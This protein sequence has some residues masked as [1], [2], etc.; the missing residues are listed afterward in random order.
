MD[1]MFDMHHPCLMPDAHSERL[2]EV[3]VPLYMQDEFYPNAQIYPIDDV[4][5]TV[6]DYFSCS[7]SYMIALAIYQDVK[8]IFITG[9]SGSEDYSSQRPSIE[10]LIGM[11]RGKGLNVEILGDTELFSGKRY[12]YI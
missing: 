11:A 1:V 8:D 3:W 7:V 10:Y 6:G 2:R 12:G 9:V 5:Q 4:I